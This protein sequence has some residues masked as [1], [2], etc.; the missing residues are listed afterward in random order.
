MVRFSFLLVLL[1]VI[2]PR[3][4][5]QSFDALFPGLS[6]QALLDSLFDHYRPNAVLDYGHARDTLFAKVLAK[7]DDT[8]RCIYTGHALYLDPTQDPTQYV[9]QG[10]GTNGINTEHSYPQSK[11]ATQ[12]TNAYS[13]MHHLFPTRIPV[14]DARLTSPFADI[15]DAQ[16]QKWF[17]K[18][19]ILFSIPSQH[20][21]RYTETRTDAFEPREVVKGDIARAVFY[22]YTM[23]RNQANAADP[24]FF[25][26][27]RPTLCQWDR[28]D[29]ADSA[30]LVKTWR[31]AGYQ[32]GKPNPFIVD[33]TLANRSWCPTVASDCLVGTSAVPADL[34]LD[35]QVVPQPMQG[36]GQLVLTLP[37]AGQLRGRL[38]SAQGREL[39]AFEWPDAP[40]GLLR[41]PFQLPQGASS[42]SWLGF[43]QVQLSGP[44]GHRMQT[45]PVIIL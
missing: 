11:G 28:Q 42:G 4:E 15:P 9:F 45:I 10:G 26:I 22:F 40:A 32:E 6:G 29:P 5:A 20:R 35:L 39:A 31:I 36:S 44:H 8:L 37:F 18:D 17:V 38:W 30:E 2:S 3:L 41:L 23:Y 33:C 21:D 25:E 12:G 43:L 27:Q 7:D 14:N 16:T 34:A 19:Q 1:C 13:D 24:N